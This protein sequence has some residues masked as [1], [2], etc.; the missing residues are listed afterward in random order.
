VQGKEEQHEQMP[1]G[2][3]SE[4]CLKMRFGIKQPINLVEINEA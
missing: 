1:L 4:N 2:L 3:L